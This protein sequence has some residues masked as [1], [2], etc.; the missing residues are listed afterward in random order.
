MDKV[1]PTNN[2]VKNIDKDL[3]MIEQK[4]NENWNKARTSVH[5]KSAH[6]NHEDVV[7]ETTLEEDS[8]DVKGD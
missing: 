3:E 8:T 5:E 2:L 1:Q 7:E 4:T 6:R